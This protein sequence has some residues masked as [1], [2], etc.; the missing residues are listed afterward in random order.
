[1]A[2]EKRKSGN[3][4]SFLASQ[5]TRLVRRTD[6]Q[7]FKAGNASDSFHSYDPRE[8]VSYKRGLAGAAVLI[9][10]GHC[11]PVRAGCADC[12]AHS[13]SLCALDDAP[14]PDFSLPPAFSFPTYAG[15]LR[16]PHQQDS[17]G[18]A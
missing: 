2:E 12:A 6:L 18:R 1:M 16:E 11:A 7:T 5:R 15:A 3:F 13:G 10:P 17:A 8:K 9:V 4:A 14:R